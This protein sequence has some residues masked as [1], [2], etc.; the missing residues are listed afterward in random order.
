MGHP[1]RRVW[2]IACPGFE[3]LDLAGPWSVLSHANIALGHPAYE[4]E[5]LA[6]E[7]GALSTRDGLTFSGARSL[8]RRA[9]ATGLPDT[10]VVAGGSPDPDV[11]AA[12][13][14]IAQ[15]LRR[16]HRKIPRL[17]SICTGAFIL[18]AAGLLDGRRATTHWRYLERLREQ[19]PKAHVV[20]GD[21]FTTDGRV[22]TSAGITAGIDLT[23][24]LVETDHGHAVAM[25]VAKELLLFLRRSGSQAQFSAM[26]QR[27]EREPPKLRDISAFVLEH[28]DHELSVEQLAEG[29]G[30]STRSLTRW[31]NREL[32]ES[33]AALVRRL[34]L[35]E[36]KRLL[37]TTDVPLKAISAR[38][39]LGDASTLWRAFTQHMGVTPAEYRERFA[40]RAQ[41]RARM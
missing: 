33:P 19:F 39:G 11:P 1:P 18:G 37:E 7:A 16:Q 23:L 6:A 28:V 41:H 22:W 32:Q 27:Q 4:L 9:T 13:A 31:C 35:E 38:T 17:V 29:L 30:T 15:W 40:T 8:A 21:I 12:E 20:D 25:G 3:L 5:L 14:R 34:R 24:A 10:I 2:F 36:A 26:L